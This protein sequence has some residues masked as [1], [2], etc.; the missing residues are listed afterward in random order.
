MKY[1]VG[2]GFDNVGDEISQ[3][4]AADTPQDATPDETGYDE[5]IGPFDTK[6]EA[7]EAN[8]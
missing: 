8:S 6:E 4:F 5:V 2:I 1:Y 7:E 3:V